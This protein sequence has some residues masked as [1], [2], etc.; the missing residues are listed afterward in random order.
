MNELKEEEKVKTMC[1]YV[2]R[3]NSAKKNEKKNRSYKKLRILKRQKK[4]VNMCVNNQS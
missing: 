3:T 2:R 1:A 4:N